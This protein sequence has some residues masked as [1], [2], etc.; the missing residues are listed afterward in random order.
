MWFAAE[1]NG[2]SEHK[3]LLLLFNF[4][5]I[6][7]VSSMQKLVNQLGTPQETQQLKNQL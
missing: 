1:H 3:K 4:F 5:A 7:L 6:S 2:T